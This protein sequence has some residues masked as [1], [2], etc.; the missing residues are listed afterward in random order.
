MMNSTVF[1]LFVLPFLIGVIIRSMFLK[2]KR[3]YILS[4]VFALIS[5]IVWL[6][7]KHLANHGVDGTVM[8]WALMATELAVGSLI[9]G[10]ISLLIRKIKH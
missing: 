4:G 2:W 10:G 9:V 3:G 8:L 7:T 6:W 5:V 1:S